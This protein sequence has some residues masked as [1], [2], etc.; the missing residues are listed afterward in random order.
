MILVS[1]HPTF[2]PILRQLKERK[3]VTLNAQFAKLLQDADIPVHMFGEFARP[4]LN[5]LAANRAVAVLFWLLNEPLVVDTLPV[6][7]RAFI[8]DDLPGYIL[9]RIKDV[10]LVL[11]TLDYIQTTDDKV[12][13][14]LVHNDV[15]PALRLLA[16][17]ARAHNVPCLHIPHAIYLEH[18]G[19]G[20]PGSDVHDLITASHIVCAGPYQQQWYRERGA[21][22]NQLIATGLPQF[23]R[24]AKPSLPREQA[25]RL[26]NY[27]PVLPVIAY[28]SSWRQDTNLL[29]CHSGVEEA[30]LE[31]LAAAKQLPELQYVIKCH[32]NGN[33]V[34]WHVA[35][36]EKLGVRC[37]VT[38]E[39]LDVVLAA[40]DV[41]LAYG[42]S[43]V[44]LEAAVVG[45]A[46]LAVIADTTAFPNDAQITK[47]PATSAVLTDWLQAA[48][49]APPTNYTQLVAKYLGYLDGNAYQRIAKVCEVLCGLTHH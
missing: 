30:Y 19:R 37:V 16:L 34:E 39:H 35:E 17:W 20:L 14:V 25:V 13:L 4:E 32:P 46:A 12:E 26:L 7:T 22:D 2:L 10:S 45:R 44:I 41:I 43:N 6:E 38:A 8:K 15:E 24:L 47:L 9:S 36:A 23:D 11:A 42:A 18:E 27:D 21:T 40:A 29:G 49:T 3:I 33:N 1:S 28:M 5:A 31:F 48:L